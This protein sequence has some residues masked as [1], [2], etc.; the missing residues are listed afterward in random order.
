M[1]ELSCRGVRGMTPEEFAA[2]LRQRGFQDFVVV[3]RPCGS[4]E[5]HT[6]PFESQA[7]ILAGEITLVIEGHE[8]LYR[9]GDVFH[10]D[11]AQ[12]HSERYGPQGVRYLV[13][14]K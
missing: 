13:G 3:E 7:L 2:G 12:E 9:R 1:G 8:K 4:L 6:H 10:L 14:R 5:L 11:H